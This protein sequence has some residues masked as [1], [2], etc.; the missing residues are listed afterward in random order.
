MI[1]HITKDNRAKYTRLFAQA[2]EALKEGYKQ[3]YPEEFTISSLEEYF[4]NLEELVSLNTRFARIPVDEE[5]FEIDLNTR[6]IN[7]PSTFKKVGL[8]VQGDDLAEVVYFKVDRFFDTTD[9][10]ETFIMIQWEAPSGRK[11]ASPA[12]F[13]EVDSETDKLIFGWAVTKEMTTSPGALRFSVSFVDGQVVTNE[14]DDIQDV[15]IKDLTYRLSTLISSININTGLNLANQNIIKFENRL[16]DLRNRIKNTPIFGEEVGEA[17]LALILNY[18][19]FKWDEDK[20]IDNILTDLID[21]PEADGIETGLPLL[22]VSPNAGIISYKWVKENSEEQ[23]AQGPGALRYFPVTYEEK[24]RYPEAVYFIKEGKDLYRYFDEER[25]TWMTLLDDGSLIINPRLYERIAFLNVEGPGNYYAEIT[26]KEGMKVS[27]L[28]TAKAIV[29]PPA[30]IS[31]VVIEGENKNEIY[32]VG[33]PVLINS[34]ISYAGNENHADPQFR[35]FVDGV[36]IEGAN[37]ASHA[38]SVVGDYT[39][40]VINHWNKAASAEKLSNVWPIYPAAIKPV[41]TSFEASLKHPTQGFVLTGSDLT[42]GFEKIEQPKATQYINWF[43]SDNDDMPGSIDD[44][45][46]AWELIVDEEGNA[47]TGNVLP[48][49]Q[50]PGDYKAVVYNIITENNKEETESEIIQVYKG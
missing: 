44:D 1:T 32:K 37:G 41:I 38:A 4:Q 48:N 24:D 28:T 18:R 49:V 27:T 50:K 35:W 12:Y 7:I 10:N 8:A 31:S 43:W 23:L 46:D 13:Q 22:A 3:N 11:M 16:V 36:E 29:P 45:P 6:Q 17:A 40:E 20:T 47:V 30:E 42:I 9:L 14:D 15:N 39:V 34:T 26:N 21:D 25:D 33:E 5:M 19:D 2:A